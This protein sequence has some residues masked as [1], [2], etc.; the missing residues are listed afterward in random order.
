MMAVRTS[1]TAHPVSDQ[2]RGAAMGTWGLWLTIIV[3]VMFV[4]GLATGALYL[5]TGPEPWPPDD[6]QVPGRGLAWLAIA[7]TALGTAGATY[8]LWRMKTANRRLAALSLAWSAAALTGAVAALVAD[9]AAAG[10][11]WDEHAYASAYWSLTG[12]VITFIAVGVIIMAAVLIQ[13]VTG[14]VDEHRHLELSNAVIYIW[15]VLGS[16][17]LL[18]ALVHYLPA[19]GEGG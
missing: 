9:L 18:L 8:G 15:F 4:A 11:R 17:V 16:S 12:F 2:P 5:E 10:F 7:L 19:I 3:L 6:I 14:L 1:R 13:T